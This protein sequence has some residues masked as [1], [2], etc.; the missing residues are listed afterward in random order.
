[1]LTNVIF[2]MTHKTF[3]NLNHRV[4]LLFSFV[5][6][7]TIIFLNWNISKKNIWWVQKSISQFAKEVG[8]KLSWLLLSLCHSCQISETY[9]ETSCLLEKWETG[10]AVPWG[11]SLYQVIFYIDHVLHC[12]DDIKNH[13]S[14]TGYSI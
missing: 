3:R 11:N 10:V 7:F 12:R 9:S 14:R 1:M 4:K 2:F 5:L 8:W 6:F 13:S